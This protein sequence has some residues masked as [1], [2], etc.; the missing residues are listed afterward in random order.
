MTCS[1]L[2][3][4]RRSG[5]EERPV[6]VDCSPRGERHDAERDGALAARRSLCGAARDGE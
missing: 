2:P 1:R 3:V 4:L 6:S 5:A